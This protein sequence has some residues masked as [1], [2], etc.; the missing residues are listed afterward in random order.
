MA[1]KIEKPRFDLR[2]LTKPTTKGGAQAEEDY[3]RWHEA[4]G[5]QPLKAKY[6]R[7]H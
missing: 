5:A 7:V 4:N 3:R 2:N 1:D 6:R